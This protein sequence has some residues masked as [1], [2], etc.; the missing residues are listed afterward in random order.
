MTEEEEVRETLSASFGTPTL[1]RS[2]GRESTDDATGE[3]DFDY[4]E[5]LRSDPLEEPSSN[6]HS[7]EPES[8]PAELVNESD[9][10][11]A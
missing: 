10:A 3:L 5:A 11:E 4:I 1:R 9:D 6:G 2:Y 8:D 7:S